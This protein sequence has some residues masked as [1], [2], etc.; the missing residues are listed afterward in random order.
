MKKHL[1]RTH[2]SPMQIRYM[3]NNKTPIKVVSLGKVYRVDSD[4]THS[5]MFHQMEGLYVN[6]DASLSEIK[7]F[8][9]RISLLFFLKIILLK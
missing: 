5:P 8:I 2:T 1:L 9:T 4:A 6:K 3:L 7:V